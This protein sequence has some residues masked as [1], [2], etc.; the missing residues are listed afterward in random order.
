[1][2]KP[3]SLAGRSREMIFFV[4]RCA[5]R[6]SSAMP[7]GQSTVEM[8]IVI[9]L[10]L[11]LLL[12]AA[13]FGFAFN[14]ATALPPAAREG[15]RHGAWWNSTSTTNP[16]ADDSDIVS[17]VSDNLAKSYGSGMSVIAAPSGIHSC[18][19]SPLPSSDFPSTQSTVWVFICYDNT[20]NNTTVAPGQPISV[21]ITEISNTLQ[22][23]AAIVPTFK[24]SAS[25]TLNVEGL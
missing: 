17:A 14:A 3:T 16:Y 21:T 20:A 25:T 2:I 1:M 5:R 9:P 4:G 6:G 12:G 18:P 7:A 23:F 8:A 11:A 22:N 15:A 13:D 10:L 19:G 24:L